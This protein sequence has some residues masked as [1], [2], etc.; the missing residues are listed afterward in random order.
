MNIRLIPLCILHVGKPEL[1]CELVARQRAVVT[2]AKD[3]SH[4]P[5]GDWRGNVV[6][7]FPVRWWLGISHPFRPVWFFGIIRWNKREFHQ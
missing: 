4:L 3:G 2:T 7:S 6:Q 5:K 1:D